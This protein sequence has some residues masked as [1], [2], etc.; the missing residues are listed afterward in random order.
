[1]KKILCAVMILALMI[2]PN[3]CGATQIQSTDYEGDFQFVYP[4]VKLSNTFAEN[5]INQKI[6][7]EVKQ[8]FDSARQPDISTTATMSYEIMCDKKNI[9]SV[10]LTEIV[11]A[12]G[13]AHPSTFK[14]ALN[15]DTRTGKFISN[16]D[17]KKI[18]REYAKA[19]YSAKGITRKLKAYAKENN[20]ALYDDFK[21]L[22]KLPEDFYF[23]ENFHLHVIFQQYEVAPYAV[24]IIDL[25]TTI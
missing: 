4:T 16:A 6:R 3:I 23:D 9:L 11:Y 17:W 13:A 2:L 19:E 24:G 12:K 15:F 25:D 18:S 5:R 21:E 1:M 7:E 20:L 22:E 10:V 8:L 14:R